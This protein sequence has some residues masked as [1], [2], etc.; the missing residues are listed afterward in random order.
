MK[1][2]GTQ[3]LE[4]VRLILRPFTL[5]DAPAMFANWAGDPEVTRY[6]T[7]PTHASEEV[8]RAVLADWVPRYDDPKKYEWAIVLR[9]LGQPIGS[10]GVVDIKEEIRSMHIGYCIGRRWWHQ[11]LTSEALGAVIRFLF[12]QVGINRVDSRH[13]PRNPN[14]GRVMAHCGMTKE[15]TVR[16]GDH[17]NQGLCDYTLYGMLADE[18][19]NR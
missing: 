8:S 2:L 11:G 13:D 14:S 18:Y 1:H 12:E 6:L 16:Q 4:T 15:G 19:F 7:W 17:N 3:T 9:E 5:A 10:M